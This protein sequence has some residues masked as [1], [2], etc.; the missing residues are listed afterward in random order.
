MVAAF[1][2]LTHSIERWLST[3]SSQRK[4]SGDCG[5][6]DDCCA[7]IGEIASRERRPTAARYVRWFMRAPGDRV[8]DGVVSCECRS[9]R[10]I[11]ASGAAR[12]PSPGP[13]RALGP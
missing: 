7:A 3:S 12:W 1:L 10:A 11:T 9:P 4:E 6:G 13:L 8:P 2:A 5:G